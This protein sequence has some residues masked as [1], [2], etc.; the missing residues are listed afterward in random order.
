MSEVIR[1]FISAHGGL[2]E[3]EAFELF[4][5]EERIRAWV[6]SDPQRKSR[7]QREFARQ[8]ALHHASDPPSQAQPSPSS[9]PGPSSGPSRQPTIVQVRSPE[10]AAP[11]L[12]PARLGPSGPSAR[13]DRSEGAAA[14]KLTLM[15]PACRE[16]EVWTRGGAIECRSCGRE[17]D[18]MLELVPVHPVG[19]FAFLFGEGAVGLLTA[20]GLVLLLLLTYGVFR[21]V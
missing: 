8:W 11:S 18:N 16:V 14:R 3:T 21:W 15:C 7:I 12:G 4:L 1:D 19:P 5:K 2:G 6:G 9:S 13:G 10:P 17:Y 20:A